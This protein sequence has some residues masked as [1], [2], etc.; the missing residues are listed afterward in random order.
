MGEPRAEVISASRF[1][2]MFSGVVLAT[3]LSGQGLMPHSLRRGGVT[4]S[5]LAG[6]PMAHIKTH[7]T[8]RSSAV[9]G[10]LLQAPRFDTQVANDFKHR[11]TR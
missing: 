9:E 10:Y 7:G 11:F 2:A 4:S 6:V 8:W 3:G 5:F 1:R